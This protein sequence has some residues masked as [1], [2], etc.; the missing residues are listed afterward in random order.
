MNPRN[1][2]CPCNSG[3]KVKHCCRE[4]VRN[5]VDLAAVLAD[6]G[7]SEARAYALIKLGKWSDLTAEEL[8]QAMRFEVEFEESEDKVGLMSKA[9]KESTK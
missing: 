4:V 6:K 3:K 9:I 1:S 7:L 2:P 5:A 8:V